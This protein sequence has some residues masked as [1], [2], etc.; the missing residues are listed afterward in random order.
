MDLRAFF[1]VLIAISIAMV[2]ATGGAA[3]STK[4]VEMAMPDHAGMP[5]CPPDDGKDSI[6]CVLKCFSIVGAYFPII[7]AVPQFSVAM[8]LFAAEREL[9][10]HVR[11]P[12]THP[13][14]A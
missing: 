2:P 10:G 6:A 12:P 14:N 11:S 3:I 1:A 5:C 4:P 9:H 13:P 8:P 7:I